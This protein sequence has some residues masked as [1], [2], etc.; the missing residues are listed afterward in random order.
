MLL[1]IYTA[2]LVSKLSFST[3]AEAEHRCELLP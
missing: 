1:L 2:V 3:T